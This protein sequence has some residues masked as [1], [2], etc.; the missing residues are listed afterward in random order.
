MALNVIGLDMCLY[1]LPSDI[2]PGFI[3]SPSTCFSSPSRP[4]CS[5]LACS[6][7]TGT[8][9]MLCVAQNSLLSTGVK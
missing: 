4:N 7:I 3:D 8:C 5:G 2:V 9:G 6:E 1:T